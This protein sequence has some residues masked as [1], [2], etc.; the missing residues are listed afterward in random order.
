MSGENPIWDMAETTAGRD[1]RRSKMDC[2]VGK[3]FEPEL[4]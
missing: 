4:E 2:W 3:A 1:G